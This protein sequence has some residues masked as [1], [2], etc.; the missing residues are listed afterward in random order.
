M[1]RRSRRSANSSRR[2]FRGSGQMMD[3]RAR[4]DWQL[5][6]GIVTA[7]APTPV[8]SPSWGSGFLVPAAGTTNIQAAILPEAVTAVNSPPSIGELQVDEIQGSIFFTFVTSGLYAIGVGIFI[9]K[10]N[11][12]VG[13][14][15]LRSPS[16]ASE[17]SDD[18]WLFLR[19]LIIT[20][21]TTVN[22]YTSV[23]VPIGLPHPIILGRG[24]ALHVAVDNGAGFTTSAG[25]IA[26][27]PYFRSRISNVA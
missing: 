1:A 7:A 5:G 6:G 13:A 27:A 19:M 20:V 22:D 14:W 8:A 17:A 18:D 23:E 9:S 24:E 11:T 21:P 12:S 26:C 2:P 10:F 16:V 25:Q 15:V 4:T 3:V